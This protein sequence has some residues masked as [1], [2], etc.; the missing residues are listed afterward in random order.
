M[1]LRSQVAVAVVY[2]SSYISDSTPSLG[3]Y[4][5][6]RCGPKN[7]KKKR[8]RLLIPRDKIMLKILKLGKGRTRNP[9]VGWEF[10]PLPPLYR[11]T[12]P[13]A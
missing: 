1:R 4:I 12:P 13:N 3:T 10:S 8:K 9:G 5:C 7:E 2:A 6:H 11:H